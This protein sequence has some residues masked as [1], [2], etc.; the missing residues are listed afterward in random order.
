MGVRLSSNVGRRSLRPAA[1]AVC[2]G[3]R[4]HSAR[5]DLPPLGRRAVL[6][7]RSLRRGQDRPISYVAYLAALSRIQGG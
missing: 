3:R 7:G 1:P 2:G 4:G 6:A 5:R